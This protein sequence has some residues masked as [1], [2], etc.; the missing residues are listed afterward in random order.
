[1]AGIVKVNWTKLRKM[2]EN[3]LK[4][5][6]EFKKARDSFQEIISSLG[7][8]W[9]GIDADNFINN[10]TEFLNLLEKDVIYF[11]ALGGY[12]KAGSD[13]YNKVVDDNYDKMNRLTQEIAASEEDFNLYSEVNAEN[14]LRTG[15]AYNGQN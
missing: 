5:S 11:E 14:S 9:E 8:C 7:E 2:S 10:C 12:F 4:N 15:G 13:T 3:T 6:E 1:M